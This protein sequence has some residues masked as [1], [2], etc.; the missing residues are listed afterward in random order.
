V[1]SVQ[2]EGDRHP[3]RVLILGGYGLI[4]LEI[5]RTLL[6][7]GHEVVGL[8]RSAALGR[9][10]EPKADWMGADIARLTAPEK[11]R[12]YLEDIDV[13]VNASGALQT[14]AR[15]RLAA[16][17]DVA[18]R[19]LISAC[20]VAQTKR[21]VQISAPGASPEADT[22]FLRTKSS[23]DAALRVS[24]LEWVI[25]K[26]G[27]VFARSAYGGTA[28]LRMLAGFPWIVPVVLADR[29]IQ[30]V[31]VEDVSEAVRRAVEGGVPTGRDYDLVEPLTHR[32]E[33][34]VLALRAW[35]G[36]PGPA[37]VVRLPA[38][39]GFGLARLADAAGWLGWRSPLRT[40]ALRALSHGVSG[41]PAAWQGV[42]GHALRTVRETLQSMPATRQERVFAKAEL[43][44]LLV[45]PA[46]SIF[47]LVSGA[48]ALF[49]VEAALRVIEGH[50]SSHLAPAYII[51]GALAD[52][53]IGLALVVRR[54]VRP[55][56]L[57]AAG[58][59]LAYSI[60][61]TLVVPHLWLDPL[62]PLVKA[63]PALVL[64]LVGAALLEER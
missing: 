56:C 13:V 54:L 18:I 35:L 53:A 10:L 31:S 29:R 16:V 41:D 52:I 34:I 7:A 49:Q 19:A 39:V 44:I 23:A 47:W 24:G 3:A 58:L 59:A 8:G 33:D 50:V 1:T 27:L 9:R 17:Q 2:Q 36:L 30:T 37:A 26:P 46:L 45:I 40:T 6:A 51:V 12:R 15:D 60:G 57:C 32:L 25:F 61:A 14:G 64:A 43:L 42:T 63:L 4:G 55:A 62:G 38:A 22:V 21:F 5:T 11:W 20:K 28:F 48:I